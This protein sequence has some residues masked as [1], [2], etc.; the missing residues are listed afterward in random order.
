MS[1]VSFNLRCVKYETPCQTSKQSMQA[2]RKIRPTNNMQEGV[3]ASVQG[4]ERVNG[5][6]KR[7]KHAHDTVARLTPTR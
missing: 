6:D 2:A 3:R 5:G 4:S 7:V 1:V